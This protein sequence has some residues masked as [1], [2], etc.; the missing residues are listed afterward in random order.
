MNEDNEL[1]QP[2]NQE[3]EE[4]TEDYIEPSASVLLYNYLQSEQGHEIASAIVKLV[5]GIKKST[6]DKSAEQAKI[7][8]ELAK[9]REE[10]LHKV[11]QRLLL[12]QIIVFII[13][14]IATSILTYFGKFEPAIAVFF[15][16]LVGYFFGR[17]NS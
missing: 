13:S 10:Y 12:L 1:E 9:L 7:D 8:G 16:T 2:E 14:I 6:L 5:E 11:R 17:K 4:Q 3:T 15:G